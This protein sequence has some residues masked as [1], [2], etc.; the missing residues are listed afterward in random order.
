MIIDST[1]NRPSPSKLEAIEKVPPPSN[2]EELRA[3]LG[4]TGYLRQFIRNYSTTAAPLTDLLNN[5]EF[6][7]KKTRK[8]PIAW[9]GGEAGGFHWL[10]KALT[11]PAVLAFPD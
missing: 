11:S 3:F 6:A 5:K 7:Y 4:M 2:V 1:D 10:K 8:F 9:G